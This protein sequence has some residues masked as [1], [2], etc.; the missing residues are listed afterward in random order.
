M[1]TG[2]ERCRLPCSVANGD[3]P[4]PALGPA[5]VR[6]SR[7]AV[8]TPVTDPATS[9]AITVA[10]DASPSPVTTWATPA[11]API[12]RPDNP[13]ATSSSAYNMAGAANASHGNMPRSIE[14]GTE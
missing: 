7:P 8:P 6:G 13:L 9:R 12:R 4:M 10:S 5:S 1:S 14:A 2:S 11:P 3:S